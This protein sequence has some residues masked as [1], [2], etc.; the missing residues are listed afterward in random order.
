MINAS[1]NTLRVIAN[2]RI[3]VHVKAKA[4][5]KREG[6]SH[7]LG[8]WSPKPAESGFDSCRPCE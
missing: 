5:A 6:V 2:H 3:V 4:T 1:E 7:R 8:G